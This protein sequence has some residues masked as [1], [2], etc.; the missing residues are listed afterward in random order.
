MQ[1]GIIVWVVTVIITPIYIVGAYS[2]L[3]VLK[4]GSV[5]LV[6]SAKIASVDILINIYV[7]MAIRVYKVEGPSCPR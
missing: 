5:L 7:I 2:D 3:V 6:S 4:V 1:F